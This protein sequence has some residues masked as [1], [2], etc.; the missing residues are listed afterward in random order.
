M[1]VAFTLL[2]GF[3][4]AGESIV[5]LTGWPLPGPVLGMLFIVVFLVV[6]GSVPDALDRLSAA[7]LQ[8]LLLL[9]VPAG[10]GVI[11]Y[12]ALLAREWLPILVALMVSTIATIAVTGLVAQ[13]LLKRQ[14]RTPP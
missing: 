11:V 10:V 3:Q 4:L 6:R 2:L 1:L 12:A 9:F 5:G 8:H 14:E 7:L 13:A